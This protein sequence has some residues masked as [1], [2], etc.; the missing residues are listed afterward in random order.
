MLCHRV[1]KPTAV[2][3][4]VWNRF[5]FVS[6]A[7]S[8]SLGGSVMFLSVRK[9]DPPACK[10]LSVY[11]FRSS[12]QLTHPAHLAFLSATHFL[13]LQGCHGDGHAHTGTD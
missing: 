5:V 8:V 7:L 10:G 4:D 3:L 13:L 11:G 9:L 6:F 2:F 1:N 12:P